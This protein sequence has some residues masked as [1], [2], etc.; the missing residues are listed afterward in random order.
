MAQE[1]FRPLDVHF[2]KTQNGRKL[3]KM[4]KFN[5]TSI[6][7]QRIWQANPNCLRKPD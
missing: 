5:I 1:P 4:E 7:I 6:Y 3:T 2:G